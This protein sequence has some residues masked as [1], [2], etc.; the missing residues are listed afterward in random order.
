MYIQFRA[1]YRRYRSW[2]GMTS[3]M[4]WSLKPTESECRLEPALFPAASL[5]GLLWPLP[6]LPHSFAGLWS[7]HVLSEGESQKFQ[8]ISA[9]SDVSARARFRALCAPP[10][11]VCPTRPRFIASFAIISKYIKINVRMWM[12]HQM[13][14][15][16]ESWCQCWCQ[17]F[18]PNRCQNACQNLSR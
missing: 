6:E 14:D 12:S 9:C 8:M 7:Y 13:S 1:V 3:Y 10:G 5:T 15:S 2:F 16:G 11:S 18:G 17:E 4:I